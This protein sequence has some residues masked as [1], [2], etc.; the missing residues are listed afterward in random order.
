MFDLETG[1][2]DPLKN[3]IT[4]IAFLVLESN[5]KGQ[6][7]ELCRWSSYVKPYDALEVTKEALSYSRGSMKDIMKGISKKELIDTLKEFF[8]V[9]KSGKDKVILV[10]HNIDEFDLGFLEYLFGGKD[11]LLTLISAN[12]IDTIALSKMFSDVN[13]T[14]ESGLKLGQVLKRI[15]SEIELTDAHDAMADVEANAEIFKYFYNS[16]NL[17]RNLASGDEEG[18]K[19][20]RSFNF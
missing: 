10:G 1:G 13:C 3:P 14:K 18:E 19:K 15:T 16:F 7:E 9:L 17:K 8:T 12:T 4:Q 6:L 5:E 2:L 11:K 20:E